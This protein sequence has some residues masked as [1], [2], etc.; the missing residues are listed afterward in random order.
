MDIGV[1]KPTEISRIAA[2]SSADAVRVSEHKIDQPQ[3]HPSIMERAVDPASSNPPLLSNSE[4]TQLESAVSD[5]Q[6]FVQS[7]SRD[8]AF[9][10]DDESGQMIVS[11][12]ER[13]TGQVIR[14]LPSEEAL[15][16]A[17]NLAEARSLLFEAKA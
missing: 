14:Q 6:S 7:V 15:K 9:A 16:L 3:A 13:K 5:M 8:I 1:L 12:T 4:R 11:I 10:V 2:T 17:E